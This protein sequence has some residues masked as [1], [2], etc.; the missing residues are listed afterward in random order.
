[1]PKLPYYLQE[2]STASMCNSQLTANSDNGWGINCCSCL[3]SCRGNDW[4]A[5]SA[6]LRSILVIFEHNVWLQITDRA[7]MNDFLLKKMANAASMKS[8]ISYESGVVT[9]DIDKTE[10][11]AMS[12]LCVWNMC[13]CI[14]IRYICARFLMSMTGYMKTWVSWLNKYS[15][16][17]RDMLIESPRS[18]TR[19]GR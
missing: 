18:N 9:Y 8:F 12:S 15:P 10:R 3:H 4:I 1:M 17:I 13:P 5:Q 11:D 16:V 7:T 19:V 2:S 6:T 14:D